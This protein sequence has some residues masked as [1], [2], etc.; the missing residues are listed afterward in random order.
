MPFDDD[1]VICPHCCC[2]KVDC[3]CDLEDPTELNEECMSDDM[4]E[5]DYDGDG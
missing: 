3:E 2:L 5:T 1:E 4:G